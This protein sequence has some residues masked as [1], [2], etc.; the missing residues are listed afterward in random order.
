MSASPAKPPASDLLRELAPHLP[1][2]LFERVS[3]R[4]VWAEL[5][6][7]VLEEKLRLKR[8]QRYG[9]GSEKLS[10]AQLDLLELEP[11]VSRD[12]V[13]AESGREPLPESPS[14]KGRKGKP[15]PGRQTLPA[16]LPRV[17]RVMACAPEQ[18]VCRGCG[19]EMPVIGF[20]ESERLEVKPAEYF[21]AHTR[22]E[23]RACPR[24]P[25]RGVVAA[26]L[27]PAI[28][29]KGLVGDG[30]VINTLI[31]K[32][33]EHQP[34]YR[35][36]A[37][38]ERE[39]GLEISR[40]TLDGWVMQVGESLVPLAA[41]MGRELRGGNYLQVDETP[42]PVQEP[43]RGRNHQAYLWQYGRPEAEVV[44]DFRM[45][46]DRAGPR[47][48]LADWN[49]I[50][51]TDGYAAYEGV[52]G[53]KLVHAGCWAHARRKFHD[54]VKLNPED[55]AALSVLARMGELFAIDAHAREQGLGAAERHVQRAEQAPA[56][57]AA[58]RAAVETARA[59]ALPGNVL[60]QA[61]NYTLAQWPK[62]IRFL[63]H[64]VLELSNNLAENSMR[65]IA[66]GRKN[67]IHVGSA[68]AGPRVAAILSVFESCRRLRLP[69]R[70]YLA[71]V[72]P[73]LRDV[74][75]RRLAQ[76]TPAAWAAKKTSAL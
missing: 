23:K 45:G 31:A 65:P 53:P 48:W 71:A 5:R 22:R 60:A 10:A 58:I 63:E 62:L 29:E 1:P 4:L 67:W 20:D 6:V 43:G 51:Q 75:L 61:A 25:E 38:L 33:A 73:G 27:A 16:H 37:T 7:Q 59:G 14:R 44:F 35:Q 15:H 66:V 3:S 47:A 11:G 28:I 26:P 54:A 13:E 36:S 12:E 41:E 68:A 74:T 17:E 70:P 9:P 24:C 32:Y 76:L 19:V 18:G 56:V 46:R 39:T 42:V 34:L 72:L 52:G 8:L 55:R 69:L 64:P 49:G 57:L 21:V 2:A 30:I 40:A 50:L